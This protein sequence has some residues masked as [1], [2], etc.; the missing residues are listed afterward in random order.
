MST[1]GLGPHGEKAFPA[2]RL[3]LTDAEAA[4]ARAG[5]FSA[6]VVLHTTKS[7]WSR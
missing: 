4:L 6:A 1:I 3:V 7:D 5:R 2:D